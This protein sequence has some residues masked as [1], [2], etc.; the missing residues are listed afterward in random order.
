MTSKSVRRLKAL[1][2]STRAFVR[3]TDASWSAAWEWGPQRNEPAWVGMLI[4]AWEMYPHLLAEAIE[5]TR[6]ALDKAQ[7]PIDDVA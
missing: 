3:I 4:G 1:G 7:K 6:D 2:V 5:R